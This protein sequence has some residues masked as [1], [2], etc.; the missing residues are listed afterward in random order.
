MLL[1]T[2]ARFSLRRSFVALTT[3][4]SVSTPAASSSSYRI[5]SP[6]VPWGDNERTEWRAQTTRQ[7]S[8]KDEVL[9][10]VE[11]LKAMNGGGLFEVE[12][13]GALPHAPDEYPLVAIKTK[14]W[15]LSKP[16]VL[17]TG[18]V[19]GYETSGVQGALL[20]LETK[21]QTY[22]RDFNILV[23][24]CVSPW[25]Y[26]HIQRW[27]VDA[28]DPNRSFQSMGPSTGSI[29]DA[30]P[31]KAGPGLGEVG[32][33]TPESRALMGLLEKL[34]VAAWSCHVDLHE[35]TDTDESEFMPARAAE[36]GKVHT[37]EEI[38][39]GFYLVGDSSSPQ[40]A[41][42]RAVIESVKKVTH[43]AP[44]ASDG[45]MIGEPVV[46]EGVILVPAKAL[47]LCGGLTNAAYATTTEVYPDSPKA[48]PEQCNAAQVAAITGALDFILS[49]KATTEATEEAQVCKQVCA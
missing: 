21:A 24:P 44:A 43:I 25:G 33:A 49:E 8:Y 5:G 17:V 41:W 42:H 11:K 45:T 34:G 1:H 37:P 14:G 3:M 27:N 4:A 31:S 20:F 36:A 48:T 19:H 30:A 2:V 40:L 22:A 18:G 6:G 10:K 15:D 28:K 38:P 23:A 26:E 12:E 32:A 9:D 35:T 29:V 7:R 46:Q 39:D 47:G 16:F 13:Y